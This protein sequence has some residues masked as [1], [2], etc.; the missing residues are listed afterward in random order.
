VRT[1]RFVR[2]ATRPRAVLVHRTIGLSGVQSFRALTGNDDPSLGAAYAKHFGEHADR[3]MAELVG[4]YPGASDTIRDLRGRGLRTAIVSTKFRYRIED[5]LKR[6][7][8]SDLVD[9]IV[10]GEDVAQHKPHP[11]SLLRALRLL[12]VHPSRAVYVGDHPV[13]AQAA[14]SA[15]IP[16]IGVLT[17]AT[18][19]QSWAAF[20][21]S[22]SSPA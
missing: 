20:A 14:A 10:G 15:E 22:E 5:I 7:D 12:D 21:P 9:V 6:A 16:F 11:E 3:V 4:L 2:S 8:S 13:D 1:T 17:G 18:D 19:A